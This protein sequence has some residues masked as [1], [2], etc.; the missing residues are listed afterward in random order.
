MRIL[1][2]SC[3][4]MATILA[5]SN[6]TAQVGV[7][8]P[9]PAPPAVETAP[10]VSLTKPVSSFKG[11]FAETAKDFTRLPSRDTARWLAI[12]TA[13][14][15]ASYKGDSRTTLAF[16][17]PQ[18]QEAFESGQTVGSAPFQMGAAIAIF[19]VGRI[20]GNS[21]AVKVGGEL[22][23]A[24]TV[25]QL[26]TYAIKYTTQRTRPDGTSYSFPSGHT[27]VTVASATVLQ[28]NFGWKVG[29]PAY[30]VAAFVAGSRLQS[31]RHHLSDVAFGAA[32]GLI[33]GRTVTVGSG[34]A[35]MAVS[36]TAVPGGAG[37]T[38]THVGR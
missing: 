3:F 35:R 36:P 13:A 6:A 29:I 8:F 28:R 7:H 30:G 34:S 25:A 32:I 27:S 22:F 20:N 26:T 37:I 15:L 10:P 21:R 5:A 4:S 14:A 18:L 33:A 38:F 9:P 31:K 2:A 1:V 23:R 19:T 17:R 12:G 24:Q 16:A 11:L